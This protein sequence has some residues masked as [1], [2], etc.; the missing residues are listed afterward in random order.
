MARSPGTRKRWPRPLLAAATAAATFTSLGIAAPARAIESPGETSLRGPAVGDFTWE[1]WYPTISLTVALTGTYEAE[2][3]AEE[4]FCQLGTPDGGAPLRSGTLDCSL[5]DWDYESIRLG[6]WPEPISLP[7]ELRGPASFWSD[8]RTWTI[9]GELNGHPV[10][11]SG[12]VSQEHPLWAIVNREPFLDRAIY[13]ACS[14][15]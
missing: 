4:R 6:P 14:V 3:A 15:G 1:S 2:P 9:E 8:D 12:V 10:R 5:E 13:G 11:C 7:A